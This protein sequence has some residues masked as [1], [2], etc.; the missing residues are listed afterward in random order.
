M[1]YTPYEA[2]THEVHTYEVQT[3]EVHTHEAYA[4]PN[5]ISIRELVLKTALTKLK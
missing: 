3:H 1:R 5:S 4:L 2:H